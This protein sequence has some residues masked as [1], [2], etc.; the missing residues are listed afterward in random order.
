MTFDTTTGDE[1]FS[2]ESV[3]ITGAPT[4]TFQFAGHLFTAELDGAKAAGIMIS[5][6][7]ARIVITDATEW[8]LA[9]FTVHPRKERNLTENVIDLVS[10]LLWSHW[11]YLQAK[12]EGK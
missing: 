8:V 6:D 11:R 7:E 1:T 3:S 9:D 12:A 5:D 4:I 10:A 2:Q